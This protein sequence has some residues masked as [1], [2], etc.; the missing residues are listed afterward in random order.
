MTIDSAAAPPGPKSPG[1]L[2]GFAS[3]SA[4]FFIAMAIIIIALTV[5]F[6]IP[7]LKFFGFYEPDGFY[8]YS[9]IRA[10]VLHG[11]QVPKTLSISGWPVPA[12]VTEPAGLY[13]VTLLPYALLSW[14]GISYYS[15]ERLIPILFG[16]LDVIGAYVLARY[17]SRSKLLALLTMFFVGLS[18]GDEARTSALIYRGD[19]FVTIF[20]IGALIAFAEVFRP[21]SR[22]RK[23]LLGLLSGFILSI[24]TLVWN[25]AP[26]AVA[27]YSGSFI[28]VL[29]FAFIFGKSEM[30]EDLAYILIG[31]ILWL[32]LTSIYLYLG[33]TV[34]Q[35]LMGWQFLYLLLPMSL[36]WSIAYLTT[37]RTDLLPLTDAVI[38][39]RMYSAPTRLLLVAIV[40]AVMAGAVLAF[41]SSFLNTVFVNNGFTTNSKISGGAF[42]ATIQEL[43]PPTPGF[44]FA[45]FGINLYSTI[46]SMV[47][48]LYSYI[49]GT[50]LF[51]IIMLL[52]FV[53]YLFMQVYDSGGFLSGNARLRF[54]INPALLIVLTYFAVTAYLQ[55]SAIRFNSLISIPLAMLS[56]YTVYWL[57]AYHKT[58]TGLRS[59]VAALILIAFVAISVGT[60]LFTILPGSFSSASAQA[61]V[62][63]AMVLSIMVLLA[64]RLVLRQRHGIVAIGATVL[65]IALIAVYALLQQPIL[66]QYPAIIFFDALMFVSVVAIIAAEYIYK[67]DLWYGIA[68]ALIIFILLYYNVIY[69]SNLTQADLLNPQFFS[70]LAWMR[71]NTPGNSVVLTLWPDGSVVEGL[72]NRTSVTDSVG[73]QNYIKADAFALWLLNSSDDPQFLTGNMSNRPDYLLVRNAWMAETGGIFDE[74]N[75]TPGA[76]LAEAP[77]SYVKFSSFSTSSNST[78]ATYKFLSQAVN[79]NTGL[80]A[81]IYIINGSHGRGIL[82]YLLSVD[83]TTGKETGQLALNSVMFHNESS[84][85]SEVVPSPNATGSGYDILINYS[86]V[87]RN[88]SSVPNVTG[89]LA[90]APGLAGSNMFKFLYLCGYSSCPWNNNVASLQ[91]VYANS[92]SRIF[93]INYNSTV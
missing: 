1:L 20:L 58:S 17:L 51:F 25:G 18:G 34:S 50:A 69:T 55:M 22:K 84:Y 60:Q 76:D 11:F 8:H 91:L 36:G 92:D 37:N 41:G 12:A 19:G 35:A 53:P 59:T 71:N 5:Y 29:A 52:S 83:L 26:F 82:P 80:G 63:Y 39:Q 47:I 73:S 61:I 30:I 43:Q 68:I 65:L 31:A 54:D 49:G 9:V 10:A 21:G 66:Q 89:A 27:V 7:M 81:Y 79:G 16:V 40:S 72:A 6:R 46:P 77:F 57:I 67:A 86:T 24:A 15:V 3:P 85:Q 75:A 14:T 64:A 33:W 87:P 88:G 4:I 45:S 13:W 28:T 2:S 62:G 78:V 70:A 32:G 42:T 38:K 48:Y 90:V 23:L 44:L 56:A 74:A 93:K